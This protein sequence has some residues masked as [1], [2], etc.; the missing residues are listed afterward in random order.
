MKQEVI[1]EGFRVALPLTPETASRMKIVWSGLKRL[2]D[3]LRKPAVKFVAKAEDVEMIG[4][5]L[6]VL[7][8]A[9][10]SLIT[11]S[12]VAAASSSPR[13]VK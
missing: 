7:T 13:R 5:A 9:C 2:E 12:D 3:L 6:K 10:E 4:E 11:A 1:F 8:G